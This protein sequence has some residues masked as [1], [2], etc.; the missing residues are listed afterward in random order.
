MHI[1]ETVH[2]QSL[3]DSS[4]WVETKDREKSFVN[5]PTHPPLYCKEEEFEGFGL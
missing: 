3:C 2:M 5:I 1:C 4:K